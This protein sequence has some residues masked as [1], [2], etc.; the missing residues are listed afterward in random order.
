MDRNEITKL[1]RDS[2]MAVDAIKNAV[3]GNVY[4]SYISNDSK[5]PCITNH[6]LGGTQGVSPYNS[7]VPVQCKIWTSNDKNP[8]GFLYGTYAL[9]KEEFFSEDA[10]PYLENDILNLHINLGEGSAL[11]SILQEVYEGNIIYS[12]P[13]ILKCKAVYLKT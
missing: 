9:I 12:L 4:S 3:K 1:I 10:N 2:L 13:F 5:F 6:I 11:P 8:S 7:D